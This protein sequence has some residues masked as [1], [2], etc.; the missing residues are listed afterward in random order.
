MI[1]ILNRKKVNPNKAVFTGTPILEKQELQLFKYSHREI[2]EDPHFKVKSIDTELKDGEKQWINVHG[3][4]KVGPITEICEK[5][6]IH[7]LVLQDILDVGQRTKFQEFPNYWFFTLK[8]VN[9]SEEQTL[10]LEHISFVLGENYLLSFQE[11]SEDYFDHIRQRIRK[12]IG[13]VRERESDY[14]LFLLIESILDNYFKV[15]NNIETE[16]EENLIIN[17]HS[18]PTPKLLDQIEKNK[19]K[20]YQLR[21]A[22]VP[23]KDFVSIIER[24]EPSMIKDKHKKYYFELRD[25]CLTLI[26]QCDTLEMRLESSSNLYFSLQGHQMNEIMKVLTVVTTMFVPL[27]FLAG[28]YGMNFKHIPELEYEWGYFILWG[29][30]VILGSGM[31]YYFKRH[32]WF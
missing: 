3:L 21:K 29:I 20:I 8:A 5:F 31:A 4:H 6:Q 26:D 32:K 15:L 13:I 16:Y 1:K 27:T 2:H 25:L 7:N 23:I 11:K 10:E 18:Q 30:F 14:L 28:I 22:I 12:D 19:R 17:A 24:I 9:P